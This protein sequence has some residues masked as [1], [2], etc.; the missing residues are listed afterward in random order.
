MKSETWSTWVFKL[1]AYEI[2]QAQR[3]RIFRGKPR[4]VKFLPRSC[5]KY[6]NYLIFSH[7]GTMSHDTLQ[8]TKKLP[9]ICQTQSIQI[10][11][12]VSTVSNETIVRC[13]TWPLLTNC[14]LRTYA[15]GRYSILLD[16]IRIIQILPLPWSQGLWFCHWA[17][18]HHFS[19]V[20]WHVL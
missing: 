4:K 9:K 15:D 20:F 7:R 5:L 19:I 11:S 16:W 17:R 8:L 6:C 2:H 10:P 1:I 18:I 3:C 13:E 12:Q 14:L